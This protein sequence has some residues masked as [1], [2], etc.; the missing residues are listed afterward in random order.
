NAILNYKFHLK[1]RKGRIIP[2]DVWELF[3]IRCIEKRK[4]GRVIRIIVSP[5]FFTLMVNDTLL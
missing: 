5:L 3:I 2:L 1:D 4:L